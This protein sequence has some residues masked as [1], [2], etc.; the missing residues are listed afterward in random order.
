MVVCSNCGKTV[1]EGKF[2]EKCGQP[3]VPKE[4]ATPLVNVE[5]NSNIQSSVSGFFDKI[6]SS[7]NKTA[8]DIMA[9]KS[10]FS[11]DTVL[12]KVS[13]IP[14]VQEKKIRVDDSEYSYFNNGSG[15]TLQKET[16]TT[17]EPSFVC[18]YL[19]KDTKLNN[20]IN[21]SIK[22]SIKKINTNDKISLGI[23]YN[24]LYFVKDHNVFF[25]KLV[26]LKQDTWKVVDVNSAL[27]SKINS[28]ISNIVIDSIEK[29][30]NL[31]LKDAKGQI[32]SFNN[33]IVEQI[34]LYINEFGMKT[35]TFTIDSI[36]TDVYEINRVL[37]DYIY[38]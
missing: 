28:I 32:E 21:L 16:F 1:Q 25:D 15:Y 13:K 7:I 12:Y 37:I 31:D 17:T 8:T 14:S 19:K 22:T 11:N 4:N 2:C 29:D 18:Y 9:I 23:K 6:G 5:N 20:T 38:K 34:N 36:I 35:D 30:G 26:S 33:D 24:L 3:L 10:D 27:S